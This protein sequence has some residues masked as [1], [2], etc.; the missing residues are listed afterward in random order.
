M[1]DPLLQRTLATLRRAA[2]AHPATG[3][4]LVRLHRSTIAALVRALPALNHSVEF[5]FRELRR[6]IHDVLAN[7]TCR[8]VLIGREPLR[9]V[10][11]LVRGFAHQ[12]VF[13]F[14]LRHSRAQR[15][16]ER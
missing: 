8:T 1:L 2:L 6:L 7:G 3:L 12:A 15:G 4:L 9:L 11:D 10:F 14:G 13:R 16:A 5:F